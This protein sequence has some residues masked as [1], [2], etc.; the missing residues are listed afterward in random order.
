MRRNGS[1]PLLAEVFRFLPK[2]IFAQQWRFGV[3]KDCAHR[4]Q[5]EMKQITFGSLSY[6]SKKKRTRR[7][8][9]LG[10]MNGAHVG[11]DTKRGMIHTLTTTPAN[12]HDSVEFEKLL[13]S[14]ERGRNT[15]RSS[16]LCVLFRSVVSI[17]LRHP[18]SDRSLSQGQRELQVANERERNHR[19]HRG[20]RD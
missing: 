5:R 7:E 19:A 15:L 4:Y 11:T 12:V 13:Y 18:L 17:H 20:H 8:E 3:A 2:F 1:G 6:L 10:E 16:P 9:F 14:K